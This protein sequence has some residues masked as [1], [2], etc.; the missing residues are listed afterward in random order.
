MPIELTG[1]AG[2]MLIDEAGRLRFEHDSAIVLES[3]REPAFILTYGVELPA[4]TVLATEQ[5]D[6]QLVVRYGTPDPRVV[7]TLEATPTD[8]GFRLRWTCAADQPAVGVAWNLEAQGPW[9][10]HGERII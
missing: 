5:R 2:R 4:Q 6:T 1:P 3:A 7:L 9:Y 8:A 10:G